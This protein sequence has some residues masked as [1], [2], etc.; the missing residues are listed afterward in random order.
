MPVVVETTARCAGSKWEF[1][2]SAPATH[3]F[4]DPEFQSCVPACV[5]LID[6]KDVGC[7]NDGY[8]IGPSECKC[9]EGF[10]G[11]FCQCE[12]CDHYIDDI[13]NMEVEYSRLVKNRHD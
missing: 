7:L 13:V 12:D 3:D 8:C 2:S 11:S 6:G 4:D 9:K 5:N 1:N 10:S